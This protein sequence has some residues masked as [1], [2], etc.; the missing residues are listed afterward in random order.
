M[1][2]GNS[3]SILGDSHSPSFLSVSSASD[4]RK[5]GDSDTIADACGQI[6]F[7]SYLAVAESDKI[8]S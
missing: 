6:G 1:L 4:S 2:F 8:F 5:I 7:F 3:G